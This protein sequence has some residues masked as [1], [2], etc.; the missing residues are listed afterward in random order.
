M[1]NVQLEQLTDAAYLL[2][3]LNAAGVDGLTSEIK[4]LKLLKIEPHDFILP[5]FQVP[6][7]EENEQ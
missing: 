4:R 5:L 1:R 2:G 6:E 3:V 7:K